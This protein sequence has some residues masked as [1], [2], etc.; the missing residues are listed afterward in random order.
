MSGINESTLENTVLTWLENL[1]YDIEHGPDIAF[2]GVKPERDPSAN[3]TDVVLIDRLRESLERI[4]PEIP[5]EAID[6]AIRKITRPES[7][8]L[9]ENNQAFHRMLTDGV[10]VSWMADGGERHDK[11]WLLNVENSDDNDWLAVN[12]F[13]VVENK[14]ERRPDVVL[15]INGLPLAV[16]ELKNPADEKDTIRHAFNQ[17]QTYKD[18]IPSL[19]VY[20]ELLVISDGL[21]ARAGTLTAGWDR[22]MPWRTVD[23]KTIAPKGSFELEILLKGIFDRRWFLDYVLNFITFEHDGGNTSTIAKKAAGYHQYHAV[24]K[25]VECT[26]EATAKTGDR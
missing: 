24:N 11:V 21:Q 26:L 7:P 23:G 3:Y 20:N 9:I 25:A 12:Q 1:G 22:F 19:F 5:C 2:D 18:Q 8:S 10:D 14:R 4:N 15:F 17:L 13:T 16:V 6:E